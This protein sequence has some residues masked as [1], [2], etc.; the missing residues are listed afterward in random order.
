MNDANSSTEKSYIWKQLEPDEPQ[1]WCYAGGRRY[2]I[3]DS[4]LDVKKDKF[5]GAIY[6]IDLDHYQDYISKLDRRDV[7]YIDT[8][9]DDNEIACAIADC[10]ECED[11][12]R[13]TELFDTEEELVEYIKSIK[14]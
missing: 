12:D 13:E 10:I 3:V 6:D 2:L 9:D 14:G 5:Y 4:I 11:C 8:L 1:Y 7:S